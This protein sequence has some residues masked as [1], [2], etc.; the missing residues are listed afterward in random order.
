MALWRPTVHVWPTL[1][2]TKKKFHPNVQPVQFSSWYLSPFGFC[3]TLKKC[4]FS[5]PW[6]WFS[7]FPFSWGGGAPQTPSHISSFDPLGVRNNQHPKNFFAP[8]PIFKLSQSAPL[9]YVKS[10][11]V[12]TTWPNYLQLSYHPWYL[13]ISKRVARI[14]KYVF[15][16]ITKSMQNH[17]NFWIRVKG[18]CSNKKKALGF[19]FQK[20]CS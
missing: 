13:L 3:G 5:L 17:N 10:T 16:K 8:E 1:W 15:T 14:P 6:E 19:E 7:L 11:V 4:H 12:L 18:T 9:K 20:A 2:N